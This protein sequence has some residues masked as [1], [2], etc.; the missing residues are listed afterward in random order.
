M[1]FMVGGI[2]LHD[3]L[4]TGNLYAFNSYC[5]LILSLLLRRV[6]TKWG[7]SMMAPTLANVAAI[8]W[9]PSSGVEIKMHP[10]P[11]FSN[12]SDSVNCKGKAFITEVC[13][14]MF[15]GTE[16]GYDKS[17]LNWI[18]GLENPCISQ[19]SKLSPKEKKRNQTTEHC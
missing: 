3:R 8:K 2:S 18:L 1:L 16:S 12:W 5:L 17:H 7:V 15:T 4:W 14:Y 11:Q 9:M 6:L 10:S 13:W 19:I